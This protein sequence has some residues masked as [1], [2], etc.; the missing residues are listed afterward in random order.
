[1]KAAK[2]LGMFSLGLWLVVTGLT[3]LLHVNYAV[4]GVIMSVL[5]IVAGTMI[6]IGR[7]AQT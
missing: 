3:P 7:L 1:M 5:A 6:L 4:L 2:N